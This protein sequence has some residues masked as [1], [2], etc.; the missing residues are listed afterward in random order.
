MELLL[1]DVVIV[2]VLSLVFGWG[3]QLILVLGL[4]LM[5]LEVIEICRSSRVQIKVSIVISSFFN[6]LKISICFLFQVSLGLLRLSHEVKSCISLSMALLL[7]LL[8]VMV[9]I[10]LSDLPGFFKLS[11]QI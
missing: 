8:L 11:L 5:V 9:F 10:F 6:V 4:V 2:E 1:T 7:C 3:F